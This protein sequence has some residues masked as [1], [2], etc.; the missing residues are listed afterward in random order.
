MSL[1]INED[2]KGYSIKLEELF[3]VIESI[4]SH[5]HQTI[6]THDTQRTAKI[7]LALQS[8]VGNHTECY[9]DSGCFVSADVDGCIDFDGYVESIFDEKELDDVSKLD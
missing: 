4:V 3:E 2:Q 6:T 1:K 8:Y 5:P 9:E 7:F